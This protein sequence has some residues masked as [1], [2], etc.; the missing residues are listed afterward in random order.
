MYVPRSQRMLDQYLQEIGQIPLLTPEEEVE[1]AQRIQ[2]GDDEALHHMVRAN[3]RFVVSVAKKYQGQGLTLSDLI[4]EGNYGLI[5]A[6]QRFDE[7]RGFKFISY[8]V[9]WIRQAILQALAEQAR[10]VR[11]PLNRIGT[12]SKI[13][14]ASARL[15]Q[16]YKRPPNVEELAAELDL[17]PQKIEDALRHQSRS[18]SVDEPFGEE[19]DNNLLDVLADAADT[20]PDEQLVGESVKSDIERA[21]ATLAPREAEITRLYF[22]IGR[23][24]P[25][26]LEEIGQE[27][28]LTRERVRQ[29]K[30]KALRKLRQK[31]RRQELQS[32]MGS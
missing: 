12:I 26:T 20:P 31:G 13:R 22:G 27:Y 11:L 14:K 2:A 17:P 4:N 16:A 1:L 32:H 15:A 25:M 18:L 19:D 8:A 10:T 30:E 24:T 7:T 28:E 29:I 6:A 23:E 3:L 5:K 21:L 9:W